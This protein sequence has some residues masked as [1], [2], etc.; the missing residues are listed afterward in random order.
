MIQIVHVIHHAPI[1]VSDKHTCK[2]RVAATM[3]WIVGMA[4][5]NPGGGGGNKKKKKKKEN[6]KGTII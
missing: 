4:D 6:T 1:L 3:I 5:N 2:Y